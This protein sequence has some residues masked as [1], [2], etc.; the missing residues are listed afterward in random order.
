MG[1]TTIYGQLVDLS[2]G[3][4]IAQH[5]DFNGQISYV[6]DVI[7]RIV[8]A[9]KPGGLE[10][11]HDVVIKT[12]NNIIER[13]VKRPKIESGDIAAVTLAGNTTMTQLL[14]KIN[15]WSIRRVPYIPTFTFYPFVRAVNLGLKVGNH[16]SV[17][18]FPNVSSYVG[19]DIVAGVIGSGMY[20]TDELT[21]FMVKRVEA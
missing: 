11:L 21:L 5:G 3:A 10:K 9:E 13:I 17:L 1:T 19:G 2:T 15:P 8:C 6:E 20:R 4:T 12:I 16:V 14:L 18:V 7:S